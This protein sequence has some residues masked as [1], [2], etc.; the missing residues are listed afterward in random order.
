MAIERSIYKKC[1]NKASISFNI[2]EKARKIR[3]KVGKKE[4]VRRKQKKVVK[5]R[6]NEEKS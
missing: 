5:I 2:K 4:N 1:F 3:E 6:K